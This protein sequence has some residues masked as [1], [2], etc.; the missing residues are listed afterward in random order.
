M[1]EQA[2][3]CLLSPVMEKNHV[4]KITFCWKSHSWMSCFLHFEW[5]NL[6]QFLF[7]SMALEKLDGMFNSLLDPIYQSTDF[8]NKNTSCFISDPQG[9]YLI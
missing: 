2:L 7:G 1:K 6:M 8:K 5:T 9:S 3:K 4:F